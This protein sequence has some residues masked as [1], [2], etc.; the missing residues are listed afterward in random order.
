MFDGPLQV[1][2]VAGDLLEEIAQHFPDLLGL[3]D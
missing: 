2:L 3:S 1:E